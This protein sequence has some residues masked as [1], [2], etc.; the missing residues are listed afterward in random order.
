MSERKKEAM[1]LLASN[2]EATGRWPSSH[3]IKYVQSTHANYFYVVGEN[4]S[5]F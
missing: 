2:L 5:V 1:M 3:Y 4:L